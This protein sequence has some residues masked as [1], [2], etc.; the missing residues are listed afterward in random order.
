MVA[1][2]RWNISFCH[3]APLRAVIIEIENN[4]VLEGFREA[5]RRVSGAENLGTPHISLLYAIDPR[6]DLLQWWSSDA[7]LRGIVQDCAAR[8]GEAE[9]VLGDPVVVACEDDWTNI[10]S[11]KVVSSL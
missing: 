2:I 11:W 5:L 1:S 9:F 3:T 8:I 10:K 7:K 4:P 6:G